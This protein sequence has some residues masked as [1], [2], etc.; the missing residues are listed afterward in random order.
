MCQKKEGSEEGGGANGWHDWEG[1]KALC[2][3]DVNNLRFGSAHLWTQWSCWELVQWG[4]RKLLRQEGEKWAYWPGL[5]WF[6]Q[7]SS[8]WAL[9]VEISQCRRRFH[10]DWALRG[11]GGRVGQGCCG[12]GAP[13]HHVGSEFSLLPKRWQRQMTY[14]GKR[15]GKNIVISNIN[16]VLT[17]S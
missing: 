7:R 4:E 16:I 9:V 2:C 14:Q 1:E 13:F 8:W 5:D 17:T 6:S 10:E 12:S 11:G 15:E 3:S